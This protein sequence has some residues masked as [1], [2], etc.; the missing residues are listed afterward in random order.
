VNALLLGLALGVVTG[1]PV[2][3]VNLAI[4]EAAHAGRAAYARRLGIGG[5]LADAVHAAVAFVGVGRVIEERPE[6]KVAMAIVTGAAILMYATSVVRRRRRRDQAPARHG[7]LVGIVLTLPNPGA[8]AAWVA[9]AAVVWPTISLPGALVL[10]A[11]VGVGS[12]LWFTALAG[13]VSSR[14]RRRADARDV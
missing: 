10:A 3:V 5:A 7:V 11:G 6:W 14:Q 1:L 8:L 13:W 12:A 4:V 9:V 2:G